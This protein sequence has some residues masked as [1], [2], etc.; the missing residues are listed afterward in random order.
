MPELAPVITIDFGLIPQSS[1]LQ[2][3]SL[4]GAN[5]D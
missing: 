1:W 4:L 2:R 5:R 3:N